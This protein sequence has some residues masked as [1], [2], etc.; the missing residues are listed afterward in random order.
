MPAGLVPLHGKLS[1]DEIQR[2]VTVD[3]KPSLEYDG[4]K[5]GELAWILGRRFK[6][7]NPADGSAL[8]VGGLQS[9]NAL[10]E[11]E[12]RAMYAHQAHFGLGNGVDRMQRL[13]STGWVEGMFEQKLKA[14]QI[15]L[16]EVTLFSDYMKAIDPAFV[17][18][19]DMLAGSTA[20][21]ANDIAFQ[22]QSA[23][24]AE[25]KNSRFAP[26]GDKRFNGIFVRETGPFL[27]AVQG[28]TDVVKVSELPAEAKNVVTAL[29]HGEEMGRNSINTF[30]FTALEAEMRRRNMMDWTPDGLVLSKL[31]DSD[32]VS[33]AHIDA[34]MGQLF[35]VAIAGPS[36]TTSW[37]SDVR[38]YRLDCQPMDKV[39]VVIVADL[40]YSTDGTETQQTA[41]INKMDDVASTLSTYKDALKA[42]T[43]ASNR[44]AAASSLATAKAAFQK[45]VDDANKEGNKLVAAAIA[46]KAPALLTKRQAVQT[47]QDAYAQAPDAAK[48]A[49]LEKAKAEYEKMFTNDKDAVGKVDEKQRS[50]KI[51]AGSLSVSQAVLLNFRLKRVTS[52]FLNNYSEFKPGNKNSRCGLRLGKE[53][54]DG[55]CGEYI[56]GGWCIGTVMDSAASR[57]TVGQL[58]RTAP[59]SMA[60]SVNV[61]VE[62]WSAE[63]LFQHYMDKSGLVEVRGRPGKRGSSTLLDDTYRS[64][65]HNSSFNGQDRTEVVIV[66]DDDTPADERRRLFLEEAGFAP[67]VFDKS[68]PGASSLPAA[69]AQ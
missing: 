23:V 4:L 10:D 65:K 41:A 20:L 14:V 62:W 36:I 21:C 11:L 30:I 53:D 32:P 47:A 5:P 45:A 12:T 15:K 18:N 26:I 51:M 52:S 3:G 31:E 33:G 40:A 7:V 1:H 68:E 24:G 16:H 34:R 35:N 50:L 67:G 58:T 43:N 6:P 28:G 13:A 60:L 48:L 27:R 39:F 46:A 59:S 25:D 66:A 29:G 22:L 69:P 61:N 54:A 42:V 63:K 57:S 8:G 56:V 44:S 64:V 38:D 49:S 55:G 17:A 37:T 2:L 19:A 9:N